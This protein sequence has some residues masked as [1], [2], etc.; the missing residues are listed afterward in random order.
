MLSLATGSTSLRDR[1]A[2]MR[3]ARGQVSCSRGSRHAGAAGSR[4]RALGAHWEEA[5][6][7]LA[8]DDGQALG[9]YAEE[10]E[11]NQRQPVL[12]GGHVAPPAEEEL[13]RVEV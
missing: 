11:R 8:L 2:D 10:D 4:V 6:A 5:Q 7:Q 13:H 12:P 1:G 9:E 3:A